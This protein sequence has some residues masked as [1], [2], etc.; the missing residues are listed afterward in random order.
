MANV[1]AT[2]ALVTLDEAK[3]YLEVEG[4]GKDSILGGLVNAVSQTINSYCGRHFIRQSLT[5]YYD[6]PEDDC[7][8][9][10]LNE[11]PIGAVTTIHDDP[12]IPPVF[13]TG[14][15]VAVTDYQVD[16][17]AGLIRRIY[18]P[19]CKGIG[20]VK[21]VYT[22]GYLI[23]SLPADLVLAAKKM[24]A[25]EYTV[26]WKDVS[27]L[28]VKSISQGDRTTTYIEDAIPKEIVQVLNRYRRVGS[29]SW[30]IA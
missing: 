16:K 26:K 27:R 28:G 6:G 15:L 17:A 20:N 30:G 5:E 4:D 14:T 8:L 21:V 11:Y 22:G 12:R 25:L 19:F 24:L 10:T 2:L 13:D 9:L 3:E 18:L 7:K 1:D 23:G 29:A